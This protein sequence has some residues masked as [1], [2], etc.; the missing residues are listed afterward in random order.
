MRAPE[1]ND[2]TGTPAALPQLPGYEVVREIG[3]GGMGVVYEAVHR[4]MGR[5]VAVKLI[6]PE[7]LRHQAAVAR[8]R[9]EVR[10]GARLTHP[11]LVIA[12]S[13]GEAGASHFLAME[14]VEGENLAELL[15]RGGPLPVG[16]ACEIIRQAAL[17]LQHAHEAGLVHRDVKPHNLMLVRTNGLQPVGLVKVLD[18]GLA[19]LAE[20]GAEPDGQTAPGTM[21]GTPDYMA[22]EQAE[23]SRSAGPPADVY[24]LGCTLFHLLTGQG[25]FPSGTV[26]QKLLAHRREAPPSAPR[27]RP[28]VPPGLGAV[29]LRA[30]AKRPQD[31]FGSAGELAEALRP[32][33]DPNYRHKAGSH[34]GGLARRRRLAAGLLTAVLLAGLGAAAYILRRPADRGEKVVIEPP[35]PEAPPAT[36][37]EKL[38]PQAD[39]APEPVTGSKLGEGFGARKEPLTSVLWLPDG[40]RVVSTSG[41]PADRVARVWDLRSAKPSRTLTGHERGITT[42]ALFPDG[43]RLVTAD[44]D[45]SV[46]VWDVE[47][48]KELRQFG[49]GSWVRGLAVSPDGRYVLSSGSDGKAAARLW[50]ADTGVAICTFPAPKGLEEGPCLASSRA[51]FFPDGRRAAT[52]GWTDGSV[53]V[54]DVDGGREL[55]RLTPPDGGLLVYSLRVVPGGRWLFAGGEDHRARL[56]DVE[57]GAVARTFHLDGVCDTVAV[58]PDGRWLATGDRGERDS[59]VRL[60]DRESGAERRRFLWR[61]ATITGVGFSPDGRRIAVATNVGRVHVYRVEDGLAAPDF[62]RR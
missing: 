59:L 7:L 9:R 21:M 48:G 43:R 15:R 29:L 23:D 3:R 12:F 24:S 34:D 4:A 2:R 27:L 38:A 61:G 16:R 14:L 6:H 35:R 44:Y 19:A 58:S 20:D 40:K 60:W 62:Q 31:R 41:A 46:R 55:K 28:E 50:D 51:D 30:L 45:G 18:F 32:F 25:P 37:Q 11:N 26:M 49:H 36:E 10:A 53:S 52:A 57:A 56:W 42:A 17:G 5:R 54:W 47:Q 8:F 33:T 39:T 1:G 13:A 22:P